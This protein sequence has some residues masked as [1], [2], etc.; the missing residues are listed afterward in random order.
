[1]FIDNTW[2]DRIDMN[3]FLES[4]SPSSEVSFSCRGFTLPAFTFGW[5]FHPEIELTLIVRGEGK[6]FVGDDIA[7]FRAGDLCLLGPNLPHTW[8]SD[9]PNPTDN[10]TCESVVIQF[11][12]DCFGDGFFDRPEL[13]AVARLL[14]H[15]RQGLQFTGPARD[16]ADAAMRQMESLAPLPRMLALLDTLGRLA[17]SRHAKALSSSHFAPTFAE[18]DRRRIDEVSRFIFD[19]ADEPLR[20]EDA[21]DVAHLSASGFS[22]FFRRATGKSFVRYVNELRVA[23]A[24]RR[25]S[26]TEDSIAAIA[27]E[28]GFGNLANFNRRFLEIKQLTP[29]EFRKQF[30]RS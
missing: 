30:A 21:A 27:F 12:P 26:E 9:Q 24:C 15:A 19:H 22:R 14:R 8:L 5:H 11:L 2:P 17:G 20:L 25:L 10:S 18:D 16:A 29:R 4:I 7:N 23:R 6:R 28:S 13:R 3:P 1:M